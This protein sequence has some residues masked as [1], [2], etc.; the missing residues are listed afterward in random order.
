MG[1]F[2]VERDGEIALLVLDVPGAPVNTLNREAREKFAALLP[3][4]AMAPGTAAGAR[5][6]APGLAAPPRAAAGAT[7][8]RA[9]VAW[10]K[11][12]CRVSA[13]LQLTR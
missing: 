1:V 3:Q 13:K 4:Q 12:A 5:S 11:E 7:V 9:T 10:A 8:A 6:P 2:R